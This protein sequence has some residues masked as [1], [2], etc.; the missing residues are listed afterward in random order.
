MKAIWND[1]VIAEADKEDLIYI[2]QNW[3]FPPS[4]VKQEFLQK[5]DTP[6]TCPWKGVC[7]YFDV[8][9]GDTVS[10]DNA[11]SYPEPLPTAIERVHKD[12]SNY[13]AFWRDVQITE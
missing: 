12:F 4:S 3:Y 1:Q 7:Q 5:S 6:Y 2:E 8:V 9:Q 10:K 11:W 13:V